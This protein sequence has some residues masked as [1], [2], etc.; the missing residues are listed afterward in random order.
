MASVGEKPAILVFAEGPCAQEASQLFGPRGFT[1]HVVSSVRALEL[2]VVSRPDQAGVA[3]IDFRHPQ[4]ESAL[5][6]FVGL[7]APPAIAAIVEDVNEV[8]PAAVDAVIACPVDPARLFV[9]V[10]E[11]AARR[12]KGHDSKR[13]TGVVAIVRGNDLFHRALAALHTVVSPVNAGAILEA[14]LREQGVSPLSVEQRHLDAI[15]A[16]GSLADALVHFGEPSLIAG[17][18]EQVATLPLDT[19]TDPR[20]PI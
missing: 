20:G 3:L 1:V 11:L 8:D 12:R 18:L 2:Y 5:A 9:R 19:G 14:L 6:L 13:L 15:V 7:P 10:V 16:S 4:S 17:A